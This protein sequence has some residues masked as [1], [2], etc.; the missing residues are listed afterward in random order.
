MKMQ[1]YQTQAGKTAIYSDADVVVYTL[2]GLCSEVG[3]IAGKYKKILRDNN[4]MMSPDQ[5][6]GLALEAGDTLWYLANFCTDLGVGLEEVAQWN[7]DKLNSRMVRG[8]LGGSG[9]NR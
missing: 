3:E 4:G 9:D 1:D 2:M 8:V 7:L 6:K 5:R